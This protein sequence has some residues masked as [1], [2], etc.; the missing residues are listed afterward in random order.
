MNRLSPGRKG[1]YVW[2]K[3]TAKEGALPFAM[4]NN[5]A[6]HDAWF[7]TKVQEALDDPRPAIS[8]EKIEA[9]FAPRRAAASRKRR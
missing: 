9:H 3:R 2:D 1:V 7:R 8:H 5:A 4:A 6:A